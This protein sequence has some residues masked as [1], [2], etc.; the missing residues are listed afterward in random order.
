MKNILALCELYCDKIHGYSKEHS[1]PNIN[2]H[3]LVIETF[4]SLDYIYPSSET[5][6]EEEEEEEDFAIYF[7][8]S[9]YQA[10]YISLHRRYGNNLKLSLTRNYSNIISNEYYIKPEIVE[11]FYLSGEER[12]GILKT[13][14]LRIVQRTW[15]KIFSIRQKIIQERKNRQ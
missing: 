9:I 13:H 8:V 5:D 14:W 15:K 12:V 1:D 6:S 10:H 3:Y 2:G 11:C 7:A 4:P